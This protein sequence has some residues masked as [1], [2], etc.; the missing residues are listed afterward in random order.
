M[1]DT[2]METCALQLQFPSMRIE[3]IKEM[4]PVAIRTP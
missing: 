2:A 1:Y 4:L 3:N